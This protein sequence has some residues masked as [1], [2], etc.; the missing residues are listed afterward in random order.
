MLR[1]ARCSLHKKR[2]RT[3]Y[4]KL[5][6]LY[7]MGSVGHIVHSS[8]SEMRNGDALFFMLGWDQY[9]FDKKIELVLMQDGHVVAYA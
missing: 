5:L 3:R 4:V 8:P 1:S 9:E 7:P 2:G 6:F